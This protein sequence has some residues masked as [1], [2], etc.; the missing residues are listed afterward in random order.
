MCQGSTDCSAAH[1]L[2]VK[3][4]HAYAAK[5]CDYVGLRDVERQVL[6]IDHVRVRR[7]PYAGIIA[8]GL[9]AGSGKADSRCAFFT[10]VAVFLSTTLPV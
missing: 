2:L 3:L 8:G 6:N 4:N 5:V 9:H 1:L 7:L 10:P